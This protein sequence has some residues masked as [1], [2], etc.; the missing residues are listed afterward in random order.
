MRE[1]DITI[2]GPHAD[3]LAP[4]AHTLKASAAH[5]GAVELAGWYRHTDM[6]AREGKLSDAIELLESTRRALDGAT[7]HLQRLLREMT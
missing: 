6:L 1:G 2:L 7:V 4:A 3:T 5:V